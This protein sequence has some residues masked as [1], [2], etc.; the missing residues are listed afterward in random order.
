VKLEPDHPAYPRSLYCLDEPPTLDVTGPLVAERVVAV[1]GSRSAQEGARGFAFAI[2]Y[3]LARAGVVVVSGGAIGIDR[4]AH[5]GAL[6]AGTTWLVSPAGRGQ[7]SPSANVDLFERIEASTDSRI[8]SPFEP[9]TRCD[10]L[11]PRFRNGVLVGLADSVIVLQARDQSGS[12]NAATW[13]RYL[14][15]RLFVAPGP[16]WDPA[17]DGSRFEINDGAEP[18]WSIP[19]LFKEL[20]LRAPNME[21][22]GAEYGGR[23]PPIGRARR[24]RIRP[25]TLTD[26]PRF[27]VDQSTWSEDEK[28]VFAQLS[29][30]PTQQDTVVARTG[31]P[32]SSTLTALLTL[33]LKDVVVEGPDGFFRCRVAL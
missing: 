15:R 18:L 12:R 5:E 14:G 29:L 27:A 11:T 30:A 16:P 19:G 6:A 9:D 25:Q 21:D 3:H 7:P 20:G 24:K 1:V 33:S 13:A 32:T 23:M 26:P 22:R 4:A 31:L 2:G 17:F 8:I 28:I 10:R